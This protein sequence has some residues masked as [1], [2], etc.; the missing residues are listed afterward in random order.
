MYMDTGNCR[1]HSLRQ[2]VQIVHI[3]NTMSIWDV[4]QHM[5][6]ILRRSFSYGFLPMIRCWPASISQSDCINFYVIKKCITCWWYMLETFITTKV[7][8]KENRE[9]SLEPTH[10]ACTLSV[11]SV[12]QTADILDGA[13][14]RPIPIANPIIGAT[15]HKTMPYFCLWT[16]D[17]WP[18]AYTIDTVF[19]YMQNQQETMHLNLRC[20]KIL[21]QN[22]SHPCI[23][24]G[25]GL[26]I[27]YRKLATNGDQEESNT[28]ALLLDTDKPHVTYTCRSRL[29][30]L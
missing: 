21:I 11:S 22:W 3:P 10:R 25:K 1:R 15:L 18:I 8:K 19:E 30:T 24:E 16:T 29:C 14:Y 26:S 5:N 13:W 20:T 23:W 17:Q 6:N 2:S 9:N 7:K 27:N 4:L 12:R 28:S